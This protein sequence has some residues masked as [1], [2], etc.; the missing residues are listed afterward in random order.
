MANGWFGSPAD[1]Q[2][3]LRCGVDDASDHLAQIA[4]GGILSFSGGL[5]LATSA[6]LGMRS[7]S[8]D[9][10]FEAT[11]DPSVPPTQADLDREL[12]AVRADHADRVRIATSLNDPRVRARILTV[13]ARDYARHGRC[14]LVRN[15]GAQ[16]AAL[17]R[18][19]HDSVFAADTELVACR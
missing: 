7:G 4:G 9:A 6:L 17:D 3:N 11:D 2:G 8:S 1:C 13:R 15:V 18:D 16:V 12:A 19:Y 10:S 5:V 14:D